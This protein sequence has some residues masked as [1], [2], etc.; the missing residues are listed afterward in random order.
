M[1]EDEEVRQKDVCEV[2]RGYAALL[3]EVSTRR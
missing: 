2:R 3:C 1:I